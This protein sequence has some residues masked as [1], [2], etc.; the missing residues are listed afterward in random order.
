MKNKTQ[1]QN[2]IDNPR[3][4][5]AS[6]SGTLSVGEIQTPLTTPAETVIPIAAGIKAIVVDLHEIA[7]SSV[8]REVYIAFNTGSFQDRTQ[9]G[10]RR[11][12][13]MGDRRPIMLPEDTA[14]TSVTLITNAGEAVLGDSKITWELIS[15]G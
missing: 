2:N 7:A 1:E 8:A 6:I 5:V 3:H 14:P 13:A 12:R 10:Q 11:V 9:V 4:V 15:Y